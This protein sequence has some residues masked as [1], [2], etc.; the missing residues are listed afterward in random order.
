M[1]HI[2]Q[3]EQHYGDG[4]PAREA[5]ALTWFFEQF[6][7]LSNMFPELKLGGDF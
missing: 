5:T 3:R 7:N 2:Y 1:K 4:N 6:Q